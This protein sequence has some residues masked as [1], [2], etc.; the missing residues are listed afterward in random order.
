[1]IQIHG[2]RKCGQGDLNRSNEVVNVDEEEHPW[3]LY[4]FDPRNKGVQELK[5]SAWG[6]IFWWSPPG[7][8]YLPT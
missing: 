3:T 6:R 7:L 2:K 8:T 4:F 5:K 1:M